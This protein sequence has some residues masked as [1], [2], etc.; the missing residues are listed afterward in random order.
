MNN[1]ASSLL[2]NKEVSAIINAKHQDVFSVLG[3]HKH[4]NATG[5][6][7]R[8]FLPEALKVEVIDS[9]TNQSVAILDLVDQAGLFEGEIGRQ[10]DIFNYR[11]R[12]S[13][14]TVTHLIEDPYRYPSMI[15]NEDLYLFCEGT[16]E[17]TYQWMGAHELDFDHVKG[18]HFVLWAPDASRV[19]V[20]GD[21]NFWDGRCHVMRKHPGAGVWEI[22]IPNIQANSNYKY[23]LADKNGK[24]QPLNADP[25]GFE[26]QHSPGT[27]SKVVKSS[28]YQWQDGEWMNNRATSSNHYHG[29]V[30]IYEVHLGSWKRNRESHSAIEH[31][32]G[33]LTY[34]ELA[35]QL[36]PYTLNMG[37]THL[38]LMPVSEFPFDGS[39]G[40]QPIGLFAPT[41]RFG[42]AEDFKYFVDCC[43]QAGIGLLL[44]W[45]PGHFP[46]DEHGIGKFD[47]SF[48]YEHEDLRQ[49]FHPDWQTLI[50]NYGRAEVQSYLISNAMFWLEQFHIDGLRVDAVASMLYL[51]Y[52]REAGEWL[53]NI[54][55]GRENLEAIELLQQ[56][57]GRAY[58]KHPGVMMIAEESTAWPGVSKPIDGGGLGFGFK[59]NMGWMNDTLKYMERDPIHRQH[60]HNDMTFSLLYSFSENFILPIS[61]DEVVHGKGSL[62]NKMPGDY[63]QKFANLRAYYGFM[64][65]HPGKKLL[66]MGCEFAQRNEW[67]HDQSLDWHLL[68]SDYHK[69]VKDLIKD[70]NHTYRDIPALYEMDCESEGFEWLDSQN[71]KQS[72]LVYLRKGKT[73]TAPALIIVNFTPTSYHNYCVGVPLSGYY[74]ECLNTD[75]IKYG[76]SN[77]VNGKGVNSEN[78]AYAG[79]SNQLSLSIPPLAT[80]I[81]EWQDNE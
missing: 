61:H 79:Q 28:L 20:V 57:N 71:S 22:F 26:M 40:Y 14:K 78:I 74:R 8:T 51:D 41:S 5:V 59:W 24:I 62:L 18:V 10:P 2:A 12:V 49:G 69:G 65:T 77:V 54:Y 39:W 45:V 27:A 66:F 64:W 76:G 48:L 55:G 63:W 38:Q 29:A 1:Q 70:L 6:V 36:I 60:H 31:S 17:Q 81:F 37:F 44:D 3:M 53:P 56:V 42:N 47:G 80:M 33:Y 68:E 72:I 46:T 50:Y 52:S 13:Y 4:P 7:V 25:Y 67:S 43:H 15:N 75:N 16:H 30:S 34:R 58:L 32:P 35:E 9:K 21:F 23:E 73:G 11:L 19:S